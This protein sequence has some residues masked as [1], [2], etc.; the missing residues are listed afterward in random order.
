MHAALGILCAIIARGKTGKGQF[1]DIA[2]TDSLVS[3]LGVSRV[4]TFF[5]TGRQQMRLGDRP[6]HV[7]RTKDDKFISI[8][9]VEPW[10]W[11]RLCRALGLEEYIP[12][13]REV[14]P[15]APSSPEKRREI[16]T[17][18]ARVFRTKTRDEWFKILW[19]ADTCVAPV[20]DFEEVFND[21]QVR[22]REMAIEVEYPT[23]GK[24]TQTG[25]AVKLSHTPGKVWMKPAALGEHTEEIVAR[26]GYS[27]ADIEELR[28][29]GVIG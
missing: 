29:K 23:L 9:P 12:H 3:W 20:Y 16:L 21:P 11:E 2:M 14:M 1:V 5:A 26:L 8:M 7:Y 17:A 15:F 28:S 6:P 4:D 10:F 19:E 18:F 24:I 27:K 25:I 22:H 13:Q